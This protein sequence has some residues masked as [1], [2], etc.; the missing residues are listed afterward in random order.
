MKLTAFC[1]SDWASCPTTR[2]SI[3]GYCVYLG[4][5]LISWKSK[6][7][8]TISRSSAEA[9]YRSMALTVCELLW[10]SYLLKDFHITVPLPVHLYCDNLAAIHIAII[11]FIMKGQNT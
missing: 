6:K 11:L 3:S 1:D 10:L 4:S 2:K 5:S 7:Q 9:E 8:T